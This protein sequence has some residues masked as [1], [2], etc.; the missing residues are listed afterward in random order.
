MVRAE[1]RDKDE[2]ELKTLKLNTHDAK[3]SL[4]C[5]KT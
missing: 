1:K 3:V 5:S 2:T 4:V